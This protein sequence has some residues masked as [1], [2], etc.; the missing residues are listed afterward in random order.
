MHL[1]VYVNTHGRA[2]VGLELSVCKTEII[3]ILLF[4]N[5]CIIFPYE[6]LL[7]YFCY[8]LYLPKKPLKLLNIETP[9]LEIHF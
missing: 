9:K 6:Q 8:I 1:H 2:K 4:I 7:T 3:L 5:Y